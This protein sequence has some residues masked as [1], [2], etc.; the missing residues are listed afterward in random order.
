MDIA[1]CPGRRIGPRV[2]PKAL[3]ALLVP[4]ITVR[5]YPVI[6]VNHRRSGAFRLNKH[7]LGIPLQQLLGD[8]LLL[9][10]LSI[11]LPAMVMT[12]WERPDAFRTV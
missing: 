8:I 3:M 11:R 10:T 7:G 5:I 1:H 4:V 6:M 2:V 9:Y 12:K